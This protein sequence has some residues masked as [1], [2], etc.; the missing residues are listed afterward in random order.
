MEEEKKTSIT[1]KTTIVVAII[2]L[3][4]AIVEIV[5]KLIE[6]KKTEPTVITPQSTGNEVISQP[7]NINLNHNIDQ[8]Y[9]DDVPNITGTWYLNNRTD[10]T[11]MYYVFSQSGNIV[12]FII[13]KGGYETGKGNGTIKEDNS[14]DFVIMD[15]QSKWNG[16]FLLSLDGNSLSGGANNE[17]NIYTPIS[18]VKYK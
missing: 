6:S 4:T 7:S 8:I 18:L 14:I 12:T 17:T 16:T 5:P 11:D 10:I 15:Q 3:L 1:A 9:G 13:Y 2:G